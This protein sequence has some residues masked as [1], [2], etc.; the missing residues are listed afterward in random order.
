MS[1][2]FNKIYLTVT[3]YESLIWAL[4]LLTVDKN[5]ETK[6]HALKELLI[7]W[8]QT[9]NKQIN[10][11]LSTLCSTAEGAVPMGRNSR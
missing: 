11:Q 4:E 5:I 3:R 10:K 1:C 8:E 7:C 6:Q 2:N 9:K